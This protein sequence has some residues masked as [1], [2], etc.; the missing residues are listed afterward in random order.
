M[1]KLTTK[2][3]LLKIRGQNVEPML[4]DIVYV[5]F[6]AGSIF[7]LLMC[8]RKNMLAGFMYAPAVMF[9]VSSLF[10]YAIYFQGYF[11][12]DKS[13]NE[14]VWSSLFGK[15]RTR[16]NFSEITSIRNDK[17]LKK[18]K[19]TGQKNDSFPVYRM[20]LVDNAGSYHHVAENTDKKRIK[21]ISE[22]LSQFMNI[23]V[24]DCIVD[25]D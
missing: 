13:S 16:I 5:S 11:A 21:D 14:L 8:I 7:F 3:N 9:F 18:P 17:Y 4:R 2:S 25:M 19:L 23:P 20:V 1:I 12:A 24:D 6:M 10:K 15:T 22:K